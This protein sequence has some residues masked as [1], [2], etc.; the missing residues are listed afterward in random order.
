MKG[1]LAPHLQERSIFTF[2]I[3]VTN[4]RDALTGAKLNKGGGPWRNWVKDLRRIMGDNP[5]PDVAFTTLIDL[6]GLPR[7]FPQLD[8][9]SKIADTRQRASEVETVMSKQF[10]DHRFIPYT[11]RHEFEALVLAGLHALALLLDAGADVAGLAQL[12]SE[13]AAL[14]PEDV[15]DGP[16]TAPSKRLLARVPS[17]RKT[18]HGP[19]VVES[20][21]LASLRAVCPRFNAW[22]TKLEGL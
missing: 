4:R 11:Q 6:Y 16:E 10:N 5:G 22:V 8:A 19:L 21:G 18:L 17:Y 12:R 7:D 1:V 2:P 14:A 20:T 15:N 13:V 9:L 3:I